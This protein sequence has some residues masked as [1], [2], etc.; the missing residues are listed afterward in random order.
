MSRH[1]YPAITAILVAAA[2]AGCATPPELQAITTPPPLAQASLENDSITL[3][4]GVALAFTCTD[5][6]TYGPCNGVSVSIDD[7]PIASVMNG[8]LDALSPA[9]PDPNGT[10]IDGAQPESAIVV[11]GLEAGETMLEFTWAPPNPWTS[12]TLPI[13][14]TVVDF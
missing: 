5:P 7:P 1:A 14:V 3:T 11:I 4:K 12:S 2:A 9:V 10:G 13:P 6:S 8:Y